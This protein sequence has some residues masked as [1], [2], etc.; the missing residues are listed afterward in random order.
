[1][2]NGANSQIALFGGTLE[3]GGTV[4]TNN[5]R[6]VVGNG[7]T[8]ATFNLMAGVHWFGNGLEITSNSVLSGCGTVNGNVVVD[9]GGLV[10]ANCGTLT[11][12]NVVTNNGVLL[13]DGGSTLESFGNLINNG[14]ID[15]IN[16]ST[17]FH[18]GL[19]NHGSI[20]TAAGVAISLVSP[21]G[22]NFTVQVQSLAGHTYQL[23]YSAS[24][25]SPTW[26]NTG[27]PQAGTGGV[28]TFTDYGALANPP[29]F[30]RVLAT[31]P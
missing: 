2:T 15:A 28:L 1:L 7:S 6:F 19:I 14:S 27:A 12:N 13:A 29:R 17:N 9:P 16:G 10:L 18:T 25:V 31:A 24:M 3:S 4:V 23:Q 26:T 20:L 30:Y 5:H 8:A 11:F 21:S 22:Q